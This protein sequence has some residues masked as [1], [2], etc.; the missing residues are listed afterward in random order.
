MRGLL[1]GAADVVPGVSGGTIAFITGI[2]DRL[3]GAL[4]AFGLPVFRL[5]LAGRLAGAFRRVDGAFL[6][7]LLA[8]IV[9]SV[10]TLAHLIGWL[11][12]A[13]PVLLWAFFFGLIAGSALWLLR[14]VPHWSSAI[15]LAVLIGL[16]AAA[17]VSLS[18]AVRFDG[19]AAALFFAGFFAI[20]AMI[21]PGVS[22][23][24]ILVLLG[25][26]DPVLAAVESFDLAALGLFAAGAACGLLA[27]ARF[28]HWLLARFHGPAMGLLTGFLA[29]SLL[30]VWPWKLA[31]GAGQL[32]PV[33]PDTW[34]AAQGTSAQL[35][36]SLLFMTLGFALVWQLERRWGDPGT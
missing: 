31:T 36:P 4:S 7:V 27:F 22:G 23:S 30:A 9:T 2:Y 14:Q 18:P 34:S 24:F 8:G 26:Y 21:L 20:C 15:V 5:L 11:L 17:A 29:G 19:G 13:H 33:F 6:L 12:D 28:L 1:M 25:M 32:L 35:L 3:L 16:L 10:G